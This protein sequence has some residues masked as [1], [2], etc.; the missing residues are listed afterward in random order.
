M[1][2]T[3]LS[4][5][6]FSRNL[7]GLDAAG[8]WYVGFS[9][10]VD[11]TVLLHLVLACRAAN[12]ALP[13]VAA[14]HVD[15]GLQAQSGQ[16]RV[17]CE[18]RCADWGVPLVSRRVDAAAFGSGEAGARAARFSVFEQVLD[19]G[20]VLLL[21]HHLDD[22]VETF[23]L[24]LMRGAGVQ[25]LAAM[26]ARRALGSGELARPLLGVARAE[27]ERYAGDHALECIEDPSNADT[28]FDRNYLRTQ[29]LPLLAAR[30]PGYRE[31]VT[32]AA[33]HMAAADRLLRDA[34]GA[35]REVASTLGDPGL[36]LDELFARGGEGAALLL[37][38]WLAGRGYLPPDRAP[39]R[40]FLQQVAAAGPGARPRL[41]LPDCVLERYRDAVYLV[42][43]LPRAPEAVELRPGAVL[44]LPGIGSLALEPVAANGLALAPGEAARVCWREGG[45]RLRLAGRQHGTSLKQ[46]LQ[47]R[48]VPP[49]WRDAVPLLA[50]GGELVCVGDLARCAS[51]RWRDA[52]APGEKLWRL[53]WRRGSGAC[54]ETP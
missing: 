22:Q 50:V 34:L 5:D 23:F 25:G 7:A 26:P 8:Q 11:S 14:I 21:A 19:E 39:L 52:P 1:G 33:G 18:Q 17:H 45:E 30:W 31:A 28:G 4:P 6:T 35:P 38:N 48:G 49:W 36:P 3:A 32:R 9:G 42:P 24:R 51:S 15:H 12:P 43:P 29:V 46:L 27:I 41:Q 53:C 40:E 10:G 2:A 44:E 54:G 47:E 20:D 16:W 13:P 37:R